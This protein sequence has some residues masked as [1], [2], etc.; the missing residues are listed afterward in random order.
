M[1]RHL[2]LGMLI[3]GTAPAI[4]AD[5]STWV[6]DSFE[7]FRAGV[8]PDAGANLYATRSGELRS[9]YTFDYNRDGANDIAMICGHNVNYCP[10]TYIYRNLNGVIDGKAR[11]SLRN[12]GARSGCVADLNKDGL[13]D[14]VLCGTTNGMAT[15]S[16]LNSIIYFGSK[17]GFFP[18]ESVNLPTFGAESVATLDLNN[19]GWTDLVFGQALDRQVRVYLNGPSG[20]DA[21]RFVDLPLHGKLVKVADVDGDGRDELLITGS[22]SVAV[23]RVSNELVQMEPMAALAVANPGRVAIADL[24]GDGQPEVVV[25]NNDP[26]SASSVFWNDSGQFSKRPPTTLPTSR[27]A[28]CAIGDVN[29]DGI[30][31]LVFANTAGKDSRQGNIDSVV[32]PG[33]KSGFSPERSV[34]LPSHFAS[35]V[36]MDDLNGDGYQDIVLINRTT[37]HSLDTDSYVYYGGEKGVS[38]DRKTLL[39]SHGAMDVLIADIDT[40]RQKDVVIFNGATGFNGERFLRLYWNDKSGGFSS[41]RK[42]ELP[43]FDSF[44]AVCADLNND[45]FL[46]WAIPNSYEFSVQGENLDRGSLIYWGDAS[47]T[48]ASERSQFLPTQGAAGVVTADLNHDGFLDLAFSQFLDKQKA[49]LIYW[50]STD[51][52]S[53]DRTSKL[54]VDDARGL[55]LGDFNKDGWLDIVIANLGESSV[56]IFWGGPEGYSDERKTTLPSGGATTVNAADL[57]NDGW[58]DLLVVNFYEAKRPIEN[59]ESFIYWNGPDGFRADRRASLPTTGGDQA[60]IADFNK[61]GLL[62]IA[63][64]NYATGAR[65]R[66]WYSFVYWNSRDGFSAARRTDLETDAGSGNVALDFNN[67]GW[68]DLMMMCHMRPSGDHTAYSYLFWGGPRGFDNVRK[69]ALPSDG[70]H[71]TTFM[72]PGNLYTRKPELIYVSSPHDCGTPRTPAEVHLD[73][74]EPNNSRLIIEWRA[75]DDL[76]S[77]EASPWLEQKLLQRPAKCWQYRLTFQSADLSNYP[78][79][80]KIE[81]TFR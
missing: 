57:N 25:C 18:T 40:D 59:T 64:G 75:A 51:G 71:E 36:A 8:F 41:E 81:T 63:I 37:L 30:P 1:F 65:D 49:Q 32:Y 26:D 47:G 55:T 15:R 20:F 5:S 23:H 62:D 80:R 14:I 70:A 58:L 38:S 12:D 68:L 46:D 54:H 52:F 21:S 79:V 7:D 3:A 13:P 73:A 35:A 56:P 29:H 50:G 39:P 10:P 17:I 2:M 53:V 44:S 69:L 77:L 4:R 9:I 28:G 24:D 6:Q 66:T 19:D 61:D 78:V 42:T 16:S 76:A 74:D 43:I 48:W 60:S 45:G 27:A 22:K 34:A 11:W 67:D 72:D 33:S 31:D